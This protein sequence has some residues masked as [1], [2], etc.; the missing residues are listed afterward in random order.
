M[1]DEPRVICASGALADGGAGVR[2]T[3]STVEG[4]QPAFAVRYGGTVYAYINRCAHV[5]MEMDWVENRFFDEEGRWILCATHG[6]LYE[7]ASGECVAGPPC[8]RSLHRLSL[9]VEANA[10]WCECPGPLPDDA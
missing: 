6:A 2:F 10:V 1:A 4:E 9:R 8:G 7:P 5:P 3:V